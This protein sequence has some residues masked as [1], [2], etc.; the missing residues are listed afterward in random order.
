MSGYLPSH[1]TLTQD[2]TIGRGIGRKHTNVLPDSV[3]QVWLTYDLSTQFMC[4][5][6]TY[7]SILCWNV[8]FTLYLLNRGFVVYNF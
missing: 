4:E 2:W 5:I 7:F 8:G 6:T 1:W 3:L